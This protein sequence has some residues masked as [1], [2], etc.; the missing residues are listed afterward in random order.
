LSVAAS[1]P[2][3]ADLV[4]LLIIVVVLIGHGTHGL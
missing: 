3:L 1:A 2:P 4:G